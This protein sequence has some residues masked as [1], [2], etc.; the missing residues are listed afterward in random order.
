[1]RFE[2]G[3]QGYIR[4]REMTLSA[5]ADP[6]AILTVGQTL[7]GMVVQP[8]TP[9]LLPELSLR[10]LEPDPWPAFA[11]SHR[12]GDVIRV[13]VKHVYADQIV[14]ECVPGID[15]RIPRD[16]LQPTEPPPCLEDAIKAGDRTEAAIIYLDKTHKRLILSVRRWTERL[17]D[18]DAMIDRLAADGNRIETEPLAEAAAERL[19][20]VVSEPVKLS[21][22]IL[23]VEDQEE[24][25]RSL[26]ARLQNSGYDVVAEPSADAA[27]R[28]CANQVF[29]LAL[30]DLDMPAMNGLQLIEELGRRGVV[31]PIAVM[32]A[33]DLIAHEY[34]HLQDLGV[35]LA[36]DKPLDMDELHDGLRRLTDGERPALDRPR[37]DARLPTEVSGFRVL[38]A[39]L[40]GRGGAERLQAALGQLRLSVEADIGVLFHLNP[41]TKTAAIVAESGLPALNPDAL[42]HLPESPVKD[43]IVEEE[44]LIHQRVSSDRS[45]RFRN[46]LCLFP[47]ESCIGI[48][49]EVGGRVEHALFLFA[50]RP[51]A[52][53][54][55]R[56]R[57]AVAVAILL[58]SVLEDLLFHERILSASQLLLTGQLASAI[59]HEVSNKVMTLDAQIA[60]AQVAQARVAAGEGDQAQADLRDWLAS[61]AET[62]IGLRDTMTNLVRLK[63][64]K[65]EH[66]VD[67]AQA[68][69]Q[70]ERLVALEAQRARV[71]VRLLPDDDLPPALANPN[72]ILHVFENLLLNA[73]Q[74]TRALPGRRG[75][76]DVRATLVDIDGAPWIRIHVT[77]NG[78]GIH[79]EMWETIFGMGV[80]TREGGSGRGL[81]IARSLVESMG[82]RLYVE[83][84]LMLLGTTFAVELPA[85]RES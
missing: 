56:L 23:I 81:Y 47:F 43:V 17:A 19:A 14:V 68:L 39:S 46:L 1:M 8:G 60:N 74:W 11:A 6:R 38:A 57:E 31:M 13:T 25:R 77:D 64:A 82:G 48:P 33:P 75:R 15:A 27:L 83:D 2:N 49:L 78:P 53:N 36:F 28:R 71:Q 58:Q 22:P 29:A 85:A 32:S 66:L 26:V 35:A 45:G 80:T 5:N 21:G 18:A 69:Q 67:V 84:S 37:G 51:Q 73:V 63:D 42:Y 40:R 3:D 55:G 65:Q 10:R 62:M 50:R 76:V 54:G 72:R 79:H 12:L 34:P 41:Q 70:A 44:V 7:R 52:F 20:A 4:P 61:M 16:E 30:I 9:G 24:V 59:T